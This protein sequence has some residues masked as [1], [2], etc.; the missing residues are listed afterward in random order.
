MILLWESCV[1]KDYS[2][3]KMKVETEKE[4]EIKK[5]ET[6]K[7]KISSD[8]DE[9]LPKMAQDFCKFVST[10]IEN[11]VER[12]YK[13]GKK[14]EEIKKTGFLPFS[15]LYT[16]EFELS[17]IELRLHTEDICTDEMKEGKFI[18]ERNHNEYYEM[19]NEKK[20]SEF[21]SEVNKI[22]SEDEIK[23][24]EKQIKKGYNKSSNGYYDYPTYRVQVSAKMKL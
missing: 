5:I 17:F 3:V 13:N 4:E 23:V 8:F 16:C 20:L 1:M 19:P 22:L 24:V 6:L 18:L 9:Q 12:F 14:D 11:K 2:H 21:I 15:N 10:S 7:E